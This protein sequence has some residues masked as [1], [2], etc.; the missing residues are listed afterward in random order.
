MAVFVARR[1]AIER[2]ESAGSEDTAT[3]SAR[4]VKKA[5]ARRR[6]YLSINI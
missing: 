3:I 5:P 1:T 4:V 2:G 6:V